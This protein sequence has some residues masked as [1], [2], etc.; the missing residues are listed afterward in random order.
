MSDEKRTTERKVT[1]GEV[2]AV[3]EYRAIFSAT[4]LAE[5]GDHMAKA[6]VTALVFFVTDS[7][8]LAAAAF[9][10]SYAPWV[11]GGPF[12]TALAERLRYRT[13]MVTCDA[14][15][16]TI[17]ALV[18]VVAVT[19]LPSTTDVAEG[20]VPGAIWLILVLLFAESMLAPPALAARSATMP[21][22]LEGERVT[23]G[24]AVNQTTRQALQV[25]GYMAGALIAILDPA[26][27]LTIDAAIYVTTA[28]IIR[29]G[30]RDRPP[31]MRAEQRSHLLRETR[32]GFQVVFGTPALRAIAVVVFASMLFAI[33]PEG[34]AIT[35][36]E[37]LSAD[38][39]ARRG[40]YQGLIMVANP[41][42]HALAG[43]LVV[44]LLRPVVRRRL[45]RYFMVLAPLA[46]VPALTSPGIAVVVAMAMVSGL[47]IA[48]MLPTLNG[49]FVQILRHGYRAR[50]FGVMN[51]GM[52]IIQGGSVLAVGAIVGAGSF[53]VPVVVGLWSLAGVLLMLAL[54]GRWPRPTVFTDA[55]AEARS[56]NRA[57]EAATAE[58]TPTEPASTEPA[59]AQAA[60]AEP[61]ST[62]PA[63]AQAASADADAAAGADGQQ[64]PVQSGPARPTTN[65]SPAGG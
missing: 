47:A 57:T 37:E 45:I 42:G 29:L 28:L 24:L 6:A 20:G 13:V 50:A 48:G 55:I 60:T 56:A 2:F 35:W 36:A 15:R 4:Q 18:V 30:L 64:V 34:L 1:F 3:A 19:L 21:L 33:V 26:A 53:S 14:G 49:M 62:A 65:Q 10:V 39:E 22:V 54:A 25:V 8:P 58:P 52:Q 11:V 61:A 9:A 12:L 63:T 17:L 23:L 31:A 40:L 38:D 32:E 7:V 59:S 44:R 46:L 51:S 43:V 5:L 41:L 16:A 27:A